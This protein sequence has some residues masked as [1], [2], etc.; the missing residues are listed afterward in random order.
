M[1]DPVAAWRVLSPV[2]IAGAALILIALERRW[3]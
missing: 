3:P 2:A 1:S